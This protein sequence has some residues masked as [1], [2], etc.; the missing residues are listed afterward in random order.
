MALNDEQIKMIAKE[1]WPDL[2]DHWWER[3]EGLLWKSASYFARTIE[4][5]AYAEVVKQGWRE[6]R[7]RCAE[8]CDNRYMGDNNR[9]DMEACRCAE[10]IRNLKTMS[11]S[12]RDILGWFTWMF[13]VGS[14]LFIDLTL[15][16]WWARG[17]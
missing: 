9:E 14:L 10:V 16:V 13:V 6:M 5:E 15:A 4:R 7:E 8:E 12:T 1:T 11:K 2:P 3:R 17:G